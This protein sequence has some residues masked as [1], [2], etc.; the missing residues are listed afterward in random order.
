MARKLPSLVL[1]LVLLGLALWH[2]PGLLGELDSTSGGS[3]TA[4]EAGP[5]SPSPLERRA[6]AVR[7]RA[8]AAGI[9]FRSK[10]ALDEHYEKH[11]REFGAITKDEYLRLA[12]A[13]RD[14]DVGGSVLEIVRAD[15][16]HTRFDTKSGAFVAF[17]RD[18][19][20]RTLFKPNDGRRYFERQAE[21][22]HE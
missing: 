17:D 10:R 7:D 13:L 18:R 11:G 3:A 16:V 1:A 21:K 8:A 4:A 22:E 15:G 5:G 19:V 6:E 12:Q 20:L 14:A 9:G 2:G